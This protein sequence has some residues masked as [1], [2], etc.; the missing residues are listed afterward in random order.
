MRKLLLVIFLL[1]LHI[2][3]Y[4]PN[5]SSE[6]KKQHVLRCNLFTDI[7]YVLSKNSN[8]GTINSL[9][10]L[11]PIDTTIFNKINSQYG[12]RKHPFLGI[13][14]HHCGLD[15]NVNTNNAV[16]ATASGYIEEVKH[17]KNGYGNY[18]IINHGNGYKTRYAHLSKITVQKNDII[19]QGVIIGY[20]GKSGMATGPHLHY[21]VIYDDNPINPISIITDN[22]DEYIPKIKNIQKYIDLYKAIVLTEI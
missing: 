12:I 1:S 8:R 5:I 16:Y 22:K 13:K 15:I 2:L 20:T 9:P 17:K 11:S 4:A 10:I 18:I 7:S 3:S 21:E 6:E 14:R 19:E